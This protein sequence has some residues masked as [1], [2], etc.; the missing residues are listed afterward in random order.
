M[1]ENCREIEIL[2]VEDNPGDIDLTVDA[3]SE[4]KIAN[5]L[6]VAKDGVEALAFL[7]REGKH[8][9]APR[10]DLI[11]LDWNLPLK[12]GRE[13]LEEIKGDEKL[14]CIPV[15]VLTTSDSDEDILNAYSLHANCYITKPVDIDQ[16]M[17]VVKSIEGFWLT[18]VK[19]A[20]EQK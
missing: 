10:P 8:V 11:L 9:E 6:T 18:V 20:C 16:F 3:L 15:C 12:H 7:R 19:F 4:A 17:R 13:V 1:H 5:H 2:L 14:R